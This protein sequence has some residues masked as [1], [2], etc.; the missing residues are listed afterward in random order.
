MPGASTLY[1]MKIERRRIWI[2]GGL[3]LLVAGTGGVVAFILSAHDRDAALT[4]VRT[5]L[6]VATAAAGV[7]VWL[8]AQRIPPEASRLPLEHA[9]DELAVQV[10]QQWERA[11]IERRLMYPE[12]IFLQ[13]R[14]SRRQV[15]CSVA[16]AV[17]R[18]G[19]KRF[20]V[21]SGLT[22]ITAE[23]LQYGGLEDLFGVYGGLGSGRLVILGAPGSGKSGAAILLLL[24]ALRH[25]AGV[26]S[27]EERA[28]V[29]VPVLFTLHGW[30]PTSEPFADWLAGRLVQDYE[31]LRAREYGPDVAA[32]LI[33]CGHLA[34]VLDGLDEIPEALRPVALRALDEQATF[35]LVV[36]TR[37]DE[38]VVAV[39][40]AHLGGRRRWNC[41]RLSLSKRRSIWS[42]ARFSR[43]F[44]HGSV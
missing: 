34:V 43:F 28:R 42:I 39:G 32:R 2:W 26:G 17:G 37:S 44:R 38:L 29:P 31:L 25:R 10:R 1:G 11:A 21:L 16:A 36:L 4:L 9:A 23:K 19:G 33:A 12:P 18:P 3:A 30:D 8:W 22:A 24:D 6:P 7:A 41:V 15:T 20:P 14:W 40:D 13:W 35:R 27:A 5:L